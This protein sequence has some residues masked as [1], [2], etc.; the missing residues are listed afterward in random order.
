MFRIECFCDDR[1]LPDVLR[2]LAGL[3]LGQ[4]VIVPVINA[5]VI[6]G[7][8]NKKPEQEQEQEQVVATTRGRLADLFA[9]HLA[10]DKPEAVDTNYARGFLKSIGRPPGNASY[11]L[12]ETKKAG[13]LRKAGKGN[14]SR[15]TVVAHV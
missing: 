12:Q 13:L 9:L 5:E 3:A 10:K 2:A 11:M 6:K 1:K 7:K 14:Q 4:P 15:Y 8:K